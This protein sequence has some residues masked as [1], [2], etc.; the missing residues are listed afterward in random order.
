[1]NIKI[2][3][4]VNFIIETLERNGCEAY[5]VGGCIRDSLLG[6]E[7]KDWDICTPA[8]PKQTMEYFKECR[9]IETGLKHGTVALILNHKPFEVTTYRID[10]VYTDNRRPDKVEF[11]GSLREDLSRR[12]FTVNAMAYNPKRG[13]MDFFNGVEDLSIGVI[14]CVG[15][16]N[17]RFQEDALRIMRA[18]R[19][20]SVLGFS[21]DSDTSTAM[22]S[23]RK[24]LNNISVERIAAEL[25]KLIVGREA[26]K[27]IRKHITIIAEIIPEIE[28]AIG[29]KQNNPHYCY[30]VLNHILS[31]IDNAPNDA[32]I[33]LA[34][35]FHDI[36]KPICYSE[37]NGI[38]HFCGHSKVSSDMANEILRRLKYD[39]DTIDTVT[40][41]VLY[42]DVDIQ[43]Q[44]KH[45]KRWL[46]KI[47]EAKFR[48][49]FEVKRADAMAQS[50]N[51]RQKK[52]YVLGEILKL[53][54]E[55]I[56]Q[57]QCFSLK[58]LSVN[59]RDLI[60]LGVTEGVEIGV[61]LNQLMDMVIDD[62]VENEKEVLLDTVRKIIEN[63]IT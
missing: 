7:P 55:V 49:L 36:A 57:G 59:G 27:I 33:R 14:R 18:L 35:L 2:P 13:I 15:D 19:L 12:D 44:V 53:T 28:P 45:I 60:A 10:G 23:N 52:I 38:G 8:L 9:I 26:G 3:D 46:N 41:L 31:S 47:G 30:D 34:M 63:K 58:N 11:V 6:I 43:A 51:D 48:Q 39:N 22:L 24:L 25:S 37:E 21:I 29:F 61:L 54:D 17:K 50:E 40:K 4:E 42:H 62:Q 5:A 1:M 56:E 16:S 32:L 20:A